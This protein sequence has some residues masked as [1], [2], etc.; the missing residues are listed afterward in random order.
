MNAQQ[1]SHLAGLSGSPV[2]T[3]A[4]GAAWP[5]DDHGGC[6]DVLAGRVWLTQAGELD[7]RV[8]EGGQTVCVAASR[9]AVIEAWDDARPALV[10]WRPR[11]WLE[12][13]ADALRSRRR[14]LAAAVVLHNDADDRAG[15][16]R[17]RVRVAAQETRRRTPGA[18]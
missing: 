9:R 8:V 17:E 15:P 2:R 14:R 7:D 11:G 5:L 6:L 1:L 16:S 3:L 10:V 4:A 13:A 18:A 12:R